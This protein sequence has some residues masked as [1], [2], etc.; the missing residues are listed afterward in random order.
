MVED[1][2]S[3]GVGSLTRKDKGKGKSTDIRM[4][5]FDGRTV[6]NLCQLG[7]EGMTKMKAGGVELRN[8]GANQ[9]PTRCYNCCSLRAHGR[10]EK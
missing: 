4:V 5:A 3:K 8:S 9:G 6:D 10:K 7:K 2:G 1:F